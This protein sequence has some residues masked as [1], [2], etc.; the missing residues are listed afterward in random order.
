MAAAIPQA[1]LDQ[2]QK[3]QDL[4]VSADLDAADKLSKA[5]AVVAAQASDAAAA[6]TLAVSTA[7]LKAGLG[8]LGAIIDAYYQ[9]GAP[10]PA[11]P[12]WENLLLVETLSI[13]FRQA[14]L[15]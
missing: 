8:Q 2:I 4:K 15:V 9:P 12:V 10:E 3:V 5:V 6:A 14:R 11:E 7:A 13:D 1:L